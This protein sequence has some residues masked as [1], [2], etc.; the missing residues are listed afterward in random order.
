MIPGTMEERSTVVIV[1]GV[2]VCNHHSQLLVIPQADQN[3][4]D[5][6]IRDT[7]AW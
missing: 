5:P 7:N 6:A 3:Y 4:T 1:C 2:K